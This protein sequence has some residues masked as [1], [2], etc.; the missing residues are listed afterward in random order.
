MTEINYYLLSLDR[1][2][3]PMELVINDNLRKE[4]PRLNFSNGEELYIDLLHP[5]VTDVQHLAMW[6][7]RV[8]PVI[9]VSRVQV[10]HE[11]KD[12]VKG[13][14]FELIHIDDVKK[15]I[16]DRDI[17]ASSSSNILVTRPKPPSHGTFEEILW[18]ELLVSLYANRM[19]GT[20]YV[21]QDKKKK[22]MNFYLGVPSQIKSNKGQ[23]LLG[24]ML[25]EEHIITPEQCDE[26]VKIMREQKR[27]QGEVLLEMGLLNELTLKAALDRQWAIKLID[28]FDWHE[29]EFNFKEEELAPPGEAM[30]FPMWEVI[31]NGLA[32]ISMAMVDASLARSNDLYLLPN[33]I[34]YLRYQP[35]PDSVDFTEFQKVDGRIPVSAFIKDGSEETRRLLV[36]LL[37]SDALILSTKPLDV[38]FSFGGI[39]VPGQPPLTGPELISTVD[40]EIENTMDSGVMESYLRKLHPDRFLHEEAELIKKSKELFLKLSDRR[41]FPVFSARNIRPFRFGWKRGDEA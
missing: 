2:F 31:F 39:P 8:G 36:S 15:R 20:L 7:E 41:S 17:L 1:Q 23:E 18:G 11:S 14:D 3:F 12:A 9:L 22:V 29:G 24:R 5:Q 13:N 27:L 30:P 34:P 37:M 28:L 40:N 4:I 16:Q 26:S 32:F 19:T 38:P 21:K 33:P 35:L 10:S 6:N 25:V